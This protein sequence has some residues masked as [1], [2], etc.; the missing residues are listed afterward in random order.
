M[1]LELLDQKRV[2]VILRRADRDRVLFG[3]GV[4]RKPPFGTGELLVRL[5][6]GEEDEVQG[7]LAATLII[8]EDEWAGEVFE[9]RRPG[10]S[11][12]IEVDL[13]D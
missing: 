1:Q 9:D 8:R 10:C 5:E 6:E 13:Q 4:Y 2:A 7:A 11:Y 12:R 3:A